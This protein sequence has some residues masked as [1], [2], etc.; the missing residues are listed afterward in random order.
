M[1]ARDVKEIL[2]V[3][4]ASITVGL[5]AGTMLSFAV[6]NIYLI[7]GL[8]ILLPG[9]LEM[10]GN[11]SGSLS[12][13]LSAGLLLGAIKPKIGRSK[14]MIGNIVA[15]FALVVMVSL[16]LGAISYFASS[17][18]FG[19]SDAK[20][21]LISVMA[22]LLSNIIEIPVAIYATFWLFRRGHDPNNTMG[23]YITAMGDVLS[24]LSLM[25]AIVIV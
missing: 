23:P 25:L 7:P 5:I 16:L 6:G 21:I 11:I 2:P 3:E 20:I 4:I 12:A 1:D 18:L 13:R 10:R 8:L 9:F 19:I 15:S 22:A 14:I 24:I 17:F